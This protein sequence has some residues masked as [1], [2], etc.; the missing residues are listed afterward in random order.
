M[1]NTFISSDEICITG[2]A[3]FIGSHIADALSDITDVTI[4][5]NL[6]SG[7]INN[8]PK[9]S[10]FIEEDI[11]HTDQ[12]TQAV[13]SADVVFHQAAQVSVQDSIED[14]VSSHQINLDPLLTI[15]EAARSS[16]TR[17]VFASSAAIYGE[18]TYLP[19]D[20]SHPTDPTSP[21][22]V[23]KLTA[24]QYCQ[25]YHDLYGV[26]T[27][28][29]RYFN[30]YGPRQQAGDYSGVVSIFRDQV[31]NNEPITIEGKGTQT[32][33]FVHVDDVVQAN[34]L[35]ATKDAAVGK[36][37]N[38]GTGTQITIR[39]LAEKFKEIINSHSKIIHVD[40]REGDIHESVADISHARAV[41]GYDPTY[42]ID[43]GFDAYLAD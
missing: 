1:S 8:I 26:E 10:T 20:E 32:R 28:V 30:V 36:A 35:A 2:G 21:Y 41:L 37:F 3:G 9:D 34:L 11:R 15:L 27:V 12:L 29:L 7:H 22:G 6:S 17:V 16:N 38:I 5:D 18:P 23:E 19:I 13:E 40:A 39:E 14:P 31:L 24:D 4:Y 25:L 43:S 42:D 33:D